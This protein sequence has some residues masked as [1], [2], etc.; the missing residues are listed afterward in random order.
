M[1]Q[2]ILEAAIRVL[3]KRGYDATTTT[4]IAEKAGI[5]VGSLYQYFPNKE[6]IVATL[7][8]VHARELVACVESTLAQV[9]GAD[10]R[11]SIKALIHAGIDIHRLN[12]VLHRVLTEQVPHVGRIKLAMETTRALTERLTE[13]L[14]QHRAQLKGRDPRRV[15]FV[16]ETIVE[17]L[18]HRAVLERSEAL[19]AGD[20]EADAFELV[21]FYLLGSQTS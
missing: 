18:T 19:T 20:I 7:V 5:S 12:P 11:S 2:V 17:A 3:V 15:A 4:A 9:K 1:V 16:I 21:E 6:A 14:A 13:L 8:E 10:L